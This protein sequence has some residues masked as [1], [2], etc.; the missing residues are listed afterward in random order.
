MFLQTLPH[1]RVVCFYGHIL[2][3]TPGIKKYHLISPS[4]E[5]E[6]FQTTQITSYLKSNILLMIQKS[7]YDLKISLWLEN[8]L[9]PRKSGYVW[10]IPLR[11][12]NQFTTRKSPFDSKIRVWLENWLTT[13]KSSYVSKI[14]LRLEKTLTTRNLDSKLE[15]NQP[16]TW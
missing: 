2:S 10:K 11:L 3:V 6:R 4:L 13:R 12:D 16:S 7:P 15:D 1:V 8:Q 9:T 14:P 5:L